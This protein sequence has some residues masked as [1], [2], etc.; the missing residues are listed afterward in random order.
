[1][2]SAQIG[3]LFTAHW[4]I[5]LIAGVFFATQIFL[6]TR[7]IVRTTKQR[8]MLSSMQSQLDGGGDGRVAAAETVVAFAWVQ[9][10]TEVFPGGTDIPGNYTRDD[11]LQELDTRIASSTDY[12]LLQRLGVIAPLLG[13]ILTVAGF[14]WLE[15]PE[16][17]EALGDILFAVM[18]LV[19]GVGAGAILA[20]INQ[21]LLHLAGTK[22]EALRITARNWFDSAIWSGIGLDTQAATIKAIH[23]IEKMAESIAGSVGL[24]AESTDR[25]VATTTSMQSAG[26]LLH[27]AVNAFGHEMKDIPE[28]LAGLHRTTAATAAALE[29]LIPVGQRAVAGLDVSVSAF[30]TA[31]ENDFVEAATLH[32]QVVEQVSEAVVRLGESTEYLRSGSEELKATVTTQHETFEAMNETMH[33][34]VLPAHETLFTA[35]GGLAEQMAEFRTLVESMSRNVDAVAGEFGSVAGKL[36]PAVDAFS[37]A[38]NG[39][40]TAATSQHEANLLTLADSVQRIHESAGTLTDGTQLL[41]QMLSE[42][43]ELGTRLG[44]THDGLQKAVDTM[45]AVGN[46]L[47][48]TMNDVA[49]TQHNLREAADSFAN[50]ANQLA[51][52]VE[53]LG[54]ATVQLGQLDETLLRL[55]DT[56]GAIQNFSRLDVDVEQLAGVLAQAATVAEAISDLPDQIRD[57]LEELVA[58][59]NGAQAKGP[60]MGWLRG[61]AEKTVSE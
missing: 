17:T 16:N 61:R 5:V 21:F 11:V 1:M 20:F 7:F 3:A 32:H 60:I 43:A 9:W 2:L 38:V 24:H 31:V 30:R 58:T 37:T 19:A 8:R 28:S 10:V 22:A 26:A 18:P 48:N 53:T 23:A 33:S 45:G 39:Q 42:H 59:H 51:L 49:P 27:E 52:F 54:P 25:L 47:Q 36:E 13:V 15:V 46:S 29:K 41:T 50:S 34:R 35:V 6:C 4:H 40:F 55:K 12:L 56:V 44:P 57:I 14:A